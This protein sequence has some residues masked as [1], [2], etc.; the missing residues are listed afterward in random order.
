MVFLAGPRQVGTTTLAKTLRA[1][2]ANPLL[3]D[4][5]SDRTKILDQEIRQH[6][7]VVFD[8]LHK[9]RNWRSYLKGIYDSKDPALRILVTGSARLDLYR[10]GGDSLHG[11]HHFWRLYPLSVAELRLST[12]KDREELLILGG[13]SEPFLSRS[14]TKAR[15]CARASTA[16][17]LSVTKSAL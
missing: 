9:Y 10:Y 5:D 4:K 13:F 6:G 12:S 7:L 17:A 2:L 1:S 15:R 8:E 11:R 16:R 14:Q 3:W